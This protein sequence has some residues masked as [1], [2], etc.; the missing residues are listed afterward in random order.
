MCVRIEQEDVTVEDAIRIVESLKKGVNPPIGPQ[1][2]RAN[3]IPKGGKTTLLVPPPGPYC[4]D[5]DS[6]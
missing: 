2:G 1:N 5:L 3:S 6:A 4:R